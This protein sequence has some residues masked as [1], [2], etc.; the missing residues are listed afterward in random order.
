MSAACFRCFTLK[1]N[2]GLGL[3]LE[4]FSC[5]ID[6]ITFLNYSLVDTNGAIW[7]K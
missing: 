1:V 4:L 6:I 2:L 7:C 5:L 3:V